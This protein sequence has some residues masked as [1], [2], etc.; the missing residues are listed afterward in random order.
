MPWTPTGRI[1]PSMK[2]TFDSP[3]IEY[4]PM[5]S[6]IRALQI[7]GTYPEDA[8]AWPISTLRVL[9]GWGAV[10][11][12]SWPYV[13][14]ADKWPPQEPPG[15][16]KLAK[17][18]R[19][20]RYQRIRT[21]N[22]CFKGVYS[23][24][25]A[26]TASFRI[27]KEDWWY[28]APGG[29]IPMP[30][31]GVEPNAGHDVAIIPIPRDERP[32]YFCFANSWGTKWG[33]RGFGYLS[34]E[35]F[36]QYMIESWFEWVEPFNK[37]PPGNIPDHGICNLQWGYDD[38]LFGRQTFVMEVYDATE[39]ERIGWVFAHDMNGQ[40]EAEEFFVRPA[41]RN[42]GYGTRLMGLLMERSQTLNRP[43]LIW[44]PHPDCSVRHFPAASAFL[45][46]FGFSI[47]GSHVHWAGGIA[48]KGVLPSMPM[49][50]LQAP[51]KCSPP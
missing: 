20:N 38:L 26:V 49:V 11:E 1:G 19:K 15:L 6:Y 13:G 7:E 9:K 33:D 45:S 23:L 5:Y 37:R 43:V 39:D 31:S 21:A 35:Y 36:D 18:R 29:V 2:A 28:N 22:E 50:R 27:K 8:G 41:Y 12:Q 34:H 46:K 10:T 3:E 44:L 30:A 4:S 51:Q 42:Q 40:L 17:K 24:A 25:G 14:D 47:S 48:A 32:G 16:D